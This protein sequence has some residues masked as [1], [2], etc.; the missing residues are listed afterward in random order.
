MLHFPHYSGSQVRGQAQ[1]E[2][3]Q[4]GRTIERRLCNLAGS[5]CG[6]IP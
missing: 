4:L 2:R 1:Y 6:L 5:I 3:L